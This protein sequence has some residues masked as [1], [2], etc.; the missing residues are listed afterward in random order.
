MK[1]FEGEAVN[2]DIDK[3]ANEETDQAVT[4]DIDKLQV[5]LHQRLKGLKIIFIYKDIKS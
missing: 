5:K 4:E 3:T 2:K 1:K